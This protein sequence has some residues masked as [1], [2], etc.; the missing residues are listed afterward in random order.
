MEATKRAGAEDLSDLPPSLVTLL[1]IEDES[2]HACISQAMVQLLTLKLTES[3]DHAPSLRLVLQSMVQLQ[4]ELQDQSQR[5]QE[6]EQR[7]SAVDYQVHQVT[8][9]V[10]S[11]TGLQ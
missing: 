1:M 2:A 11:H 8:A 3:V 5:I 7:T 9:A 4:K 10:I 6:A